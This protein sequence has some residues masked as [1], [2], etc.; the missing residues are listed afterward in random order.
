MTEKMGPAQAVAAGAALLD[1]VWT[2]MGSSDPRVWVDV[3]VE[4]VVV[5]NSL[6]GNGERDLRELDM[7][8]NEDCVFGWLSP[9]IIAGL[10]GDE[11]TERSYINAK[12]EIWSYLGQ[13]A[14]KHVG[15][16][17]W[18]IEYGFLEPEQWECEPEEGGETHEF[19]GDWCLY[20]QWDQ[21]QLL[22]DAWIELVGQEYHARHGVYPNGYE[23]RRDALRGL[24]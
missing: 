16:H 10:S 19:F 17:L 9:V 3:L 8:S 12:D 7:D 11:V 13:P 4:R 14:V 22:W 5:E 21:Q 23:Q 20:E 2:R 18:T 6:T 15:H 24:G 1:R